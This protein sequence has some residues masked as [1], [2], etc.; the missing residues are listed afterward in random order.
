M[1]E[2]PPPPPRRAMTVTLTSWCCA[3]ANPDK[4]AEIA[5]DPRRRGRPAAPAADVPDVVEDADTARGQRPAEGAWRSARRP[6][7]RRSPTTPASRS[8]RSAARPASTSARYA[9]DERDLRR[10]PGASCSTSSAG[11]GPTERTARFRTVAARALA[12]RARGRASRAC[13]T[14]AIADRASGATAAS[15]TTRCSCPTRA[16]A[17][18][19]PR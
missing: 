10:Q 3:S 19:S 12:R 4:V 8:T 6:G 1:A 17:A 18:R 14:G 7:C 5:D 11:V 13:A 2:P 15:A 9:G 16:T